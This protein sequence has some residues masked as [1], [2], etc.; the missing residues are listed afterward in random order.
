VQALINSTQAVDITNRRLGRSLLDLLNTALQNFQRGQTYLG[1]TALSAY[2]QQ[3]ALANGQEISADSVGKLTSQASVV[4]GCGATGF[5]LVTSPTSATV[6]TRSPASYALAVTPIGG[7]TGKV[8]L[9]C[10]GVPK[11]IDCSFSSRSVALDG[12]SQSRV[13]LTVTAGGSGNCVSTTGAIGA[14]D[15]EVRHCSDDPEW[16]KRPRKPAPGTYSFILQAT[17]GGPVRNTLLTLVI[18]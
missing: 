11:G 14:D 1:N 10:I 12:S 4:L 8:A 9:A 13:T 15:L 5:S 18:K 3:L 17:S 7:F 2:M 6:S 16:H